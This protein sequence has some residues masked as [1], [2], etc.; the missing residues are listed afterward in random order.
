VQI[1]RAVLKPAAIWLVIGG[2]LT[3]ISSIIVFIVEGRYG[4]TVGTLI[5]LVLVLVAGSEISQA[6]SVWRSEAGGWKGIVT[7]LGLSLLSRAFI[8]YSSTGSELSIWLAV[9]G[10]AIVGAGE[11]AIF[12]F[13]LVKKDYFVPPEEERVAA[14][15]RL[16]VSAVKT[17]SDCPSCHGLVEKDWESC[18][19][20]G[21]V[22]PKV[23]A[24]CGT[25]LESGQ[26]KCSCCGTEVER[27]DVLMKTV[28]A[29]RAV[30]EEDA[31]PET[32]SS[33]YARLAEGLLKAGR[34]EEALA[35]Y[36]KAIEYTSFDRKR[37]HFMVRKATILKNTG[38]I[39]EALRILDE[40]IRLDPNDYAGAKALRESIL[41]PPKEG[42]ACAV[43]GPA[44]VA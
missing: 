32:K 24:N 41:N 39:Q 8:L 13:L 11:L 2:A 34:T 7:W 3:I 9:Y 37:C 17:V 15:G 19:Y 42:E 6:R 5:V 22:L 4:T 29:L 30:T 18:P 21:T 35:S 1:G 31:L 12:A 20:C 38:S 43:P 28:E 44:T 23:C 25:A 16:E 40:A 14:M 27:S 36:E 26:T 33:R 10:G